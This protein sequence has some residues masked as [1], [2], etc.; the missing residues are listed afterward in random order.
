[1]P[2]AS[3]IQQAADT[4]VS[5]QV[6]VPN[7]S[8][9]FGQMSCAQIPQLRTFFMLPK[10]AAN[11]PYRL[12]GIRADATSLHDPSYYIYNNRNHNTEIEQFLRS[13]KPRPAQGMVRLMFSIRKASQFGPI[14]SSARSTARCRQG[15]GPHRALLTATSHPRSCCVPGTGWV[16]QLAAELPAGVGAGT[17]S[18]PL[19]IF[20]STVQAVNSILPPLSGTNAPQTTMKTSVQTAYK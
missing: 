8:I 20:P 5:S 6:P 19:L 4:R 10:T 17:H 1:M 7:Q 9:Y 16:C 14:L 11:I 13:P 3:C 2:A 15:C 12:A 18:P